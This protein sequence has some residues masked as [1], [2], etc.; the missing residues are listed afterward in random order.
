MRITRRATFAAGAA[1]ALPRPAIAQAD[2]RPAITVAV[3][4]ISNS[5]TFETPREQS[6]VGYRAFYTYSE[7]LIDFDWTGSMDQVPGLATAWSRA[8]DARSVEVT[9]R[10]GVRFHDGRPMTAE[11]VAFSFGP[12]RLFGTG[13]TGPKEPPNEVKAVARLSYPKL[14]KVE[15]LAKDR[16][17][18]VLNGPDATMAGRLAQNTGVILSANAFAAAPTWLDWARRPIG[19]GP[20]RIAEFRPDSFVVFEAFDDYWGGRPPARS[21]RFVEIPEVSSRINGLLSGEF[22]F[23]CDI[24]PDQIAPIERNPRFEVQGSPINNIRIMAF[25]HNHPQL[26]DPRIRRAMS[27]AIDRRAIV[28]ALWSGRTRI[29]K[30]LQLEAYAAMFVPEHGEPRHDPAE[31]RRLLAEA[32]YR[33]EPIPYRLLKDYYTNQVGTAQICVEMWRAVGLNVQMSLQENWSQV[34]GAKIERGIRDWSNTSLFM[35]PVAGLLRGMGPGG[36]QQRDGEWTNAEFNRLAGVV[37]S[38]IEP[39]ERRAA[40]ARMLTIAEH[41]DPAYLI[42]HQAATFIAKRRD[43]RW[44]AS[45]GWPLDFRARNFA[46]GS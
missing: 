8:A 2:Q 35:D 20:Y 15:I 21:I 41:D 46:F 27:L 24:P 10:P 17:R 1:L 43:I 23:A 39:S 36:A 19:T 6:N 26:R 12:E 37:E 45:Q 44:R 13:A 30:G 7:T 18:F 32:G 28:D 5:N 14:E 33:G 31:A 4:K 11:D 38:S 22:H 25:D 16:V 3:Q 34:T 29:P 42:L 9:L 40:F